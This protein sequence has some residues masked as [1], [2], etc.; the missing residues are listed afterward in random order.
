[1]PLFIHSQGGPRALSRYPSS[2]VARGAKCHPALREMLPTED[3]PFVQ[4]QDWRD[5]SNPAGWRGEAPEGPTFGFAGKA[6]PGSNGAPQASLQP[7]PGAA[8]PQLAALRKR[9]G[10][11]WR[12]QI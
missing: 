6:P 3:S 4:K 1:M 2:L 11:G 8:L 10:I 12:H 5:S 7:T 9:L